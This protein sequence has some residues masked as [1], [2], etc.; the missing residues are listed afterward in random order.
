MAEIIS[1]YPFF[2]E[3]FLSISI[4]H[5]F[6]VL[7]PGPDFAVV[8]RQSIVNGRKHAII[9]S[10]GI[11]V[12]IIVHIIYCIVGIT[13]I[14]STYSILIRIIKYLGGSYLLF[15][16]I[17]SIF[18]TQINL[19]IDDEL[20]KRNN[21]YFRKSFLLGFL[22]NVLNPKASLFF[23]SL[24]TIFIDF[25]TPALIQVIYGLWMVIV[26][27]IWFCLVSILF[28]TN[29]SKIFISKYALLIDKIMG[30]LLVI[31]S[32]KIMFL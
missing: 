16:G 12:G 24:F 29:I 6:A 2:V 25:N 22:T 19:N 5:L 9:T 15:L 3:Q 8:L 23:L 20:L 14:S 11:G 30:V 18:T 4:I 31:I 32:I 7:S 26:T 10:L 1:K 28:T 17:K 21:N 13:F 27:S